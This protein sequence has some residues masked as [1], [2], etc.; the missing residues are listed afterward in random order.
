MRCACTDFIILEW[1]I[2][3]VQYHLAPFLFN[4]GFRN[5]YHKNQTYNE[6]LGTG[7]D[8]SEQAIKWLVRGV[9]IPTTRI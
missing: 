9:I 7:P 3:S 4:C 2:K 8:Y 6:M 1:F 5:C